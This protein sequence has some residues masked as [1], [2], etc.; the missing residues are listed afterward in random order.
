MQFDNLFI[1]CAGFLME[2]VDILRD[3]MGYFACIHKAG[4]RAVAGIR[5]GIFHLHIA[6]K[7]ASP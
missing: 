3:D 4:D 5:F 2:A 6:G 7:L 1:R